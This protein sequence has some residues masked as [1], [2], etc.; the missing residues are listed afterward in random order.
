MLSFALASAITSTCPPI[1]TDS[2]SM[3]VLATL[4]AA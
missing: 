1:A 3:T 2:N 4:E